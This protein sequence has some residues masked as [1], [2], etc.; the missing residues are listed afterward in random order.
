MTDL[1]LETQYTTPQYLHSHGT[2][3]ISLN[4]SGPEGLAFMHDTNLDTMQVQNVGCVNQPQ[5][6]VST[7]TRSSRTLPVEKM[8][9][10]SRPR[11]KLQSEAVAAQLLPSPD[12]PP[13][14]SDFQT[15]ASKPPVP[16]GPAWPAQPADRMLP[17]TQGPPPPPDVLRGSALQAIV[18]KL[19]MPM[20]PGPAWPAQPANRKLTATQGPPPAPNVVS[21][22]PAWPAQPTGHMLPTTQRPPLS[23][24]TFKAKPALQTAVSKPFEPPVPARQVGL[25]ERRDGLRAAVPRSVSLHVFN[26]SEE[27]TSA[28]LVDHIKSTTGVQVAECEKLT[29]DLKADLGNPNGKLNSIID[30]EL[31]ADKIG[32][33]IH[34][35]WTNNCPEK[36]I[37]AKK[38]PWWNPEIAKLRKETR[39][40][41]N[42]A[43]RS[44]DF[45]LYARKLTEYSKAVRKAK[46]KAWKNHC[47]Q[48]GSIPEGMRLTKALATTKS[49]PLTSIRRSDGG[50][51]ET[52]LET[53]KEDERAE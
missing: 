30:I 47:D 25:M 15:A 42:D 33:A 31:E 2:L 21:P 53:L 4:D 40:V 41:F 34:S 51:T 5:K 50:M 13:A 46:R 3:N 10:R 39:A 48:I 26:L 9:L 20:P 43:K 14:G 23:P 44:N 24:D 19:P 49:V 29:D 36:K 8:Q 16:P 11:R 18:P 38:V 22:C 52:G 28:D 1:N 27:T 37:L 32:Q 35:A 17:A 7:P 12:A 45:E 6:E